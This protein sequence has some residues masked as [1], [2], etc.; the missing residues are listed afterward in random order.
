MKVWYLVALVTIS[1]V[2][3]GRVA[4]AS[5]QAGA[6]ESSVRTFMALVAHDVTREGPLAWLRYFDDSPA[7]FMAVNGQLA[8]PDSNAA[9]VGTREFAR[10]IQHI[11]LNWGQDLRVDPLLSDLQSWSV[12]GR[13][14]RRTLPGTE[15]KSTVSL[16]AS[17]NFEM[18]DGD[19][20][21]PTGPRRYSLHLLVKQQLAAASRLTV[22]ISRVEIEG[23]GTYG[24]LS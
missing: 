3:N 4:S 13:R 1:S 7:F 11:E 8:F 16:P 14:F 19:S 21:T 20:A 24:N 17:L 15:S 12:H 6:T 2:A 10:R 22:A 5:S 23:S 18:V 9:K